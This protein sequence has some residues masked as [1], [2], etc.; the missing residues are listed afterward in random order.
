MSFLV[1]KS[2]INNRMAEEPSK[3]SPFYVEHPEHLKVTGVP[4]VVF[5]G[6]GETC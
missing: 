4:T 2:D 5:H 1:S 6:L 3:D